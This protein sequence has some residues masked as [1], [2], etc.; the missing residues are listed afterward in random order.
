MIDENKQNVSGTKKLNTLLLRE[1]VT[2]MQK[3]KWEEKKREDEKIRK[4]ER[5]NGKKEMEIE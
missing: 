2:R 3:E 5:R 1:N 4:G